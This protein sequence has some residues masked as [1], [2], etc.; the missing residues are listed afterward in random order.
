MQ[1]E[2]SIEANREIALT[3]SEMA[4]T[5]IPGY[6]H[7]IYKYKVEELIGIIESKIFI[8]DTTV[9]TADYI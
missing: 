4:K 2:T 8:I 9:K 3:I 6:P 5:R 1:K 7:F